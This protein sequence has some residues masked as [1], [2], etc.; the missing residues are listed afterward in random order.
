ML[1]QNQRSQLLPL[2]W[3]CKR[4]HPLN[5][6][7]WHPH[8]YPPLP[9]N[10]DITSCMSWHIHE[11]GIQNVFVCNTSMSL[12]AQ[13]HN[14]CLVKDQDSWS[15]PQSMYKCTFNY[16]DRDHRGHIAIAI[17]MGH[18]VM[19]YWPEIPNTLNHSYDIGGDIAKS[20][21][22]CSWQCLRSSIVRDCNDSSDLAI[23]HSK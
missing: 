17:S 10:I 21:I 22:C 3:S 1:R 9:E 6:G 16:W 23:E 8:A 12:G 14:D 11:I 7:G 15:S 20:C 13:Y 2:C 4:V 18:I 19:I 5:A